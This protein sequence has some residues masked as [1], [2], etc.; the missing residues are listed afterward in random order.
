MAR[1]FGVSA[2]RR[3]KSDDDPYGA[4]AVCGRLSVPELSSFT[5]EE[6]TIE[7]CVIRIAA[8]CNIGYAKLS[9]SR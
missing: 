6:L 3:S 7:M 2:S 4:K 8:V 5:P 1:E 9:V